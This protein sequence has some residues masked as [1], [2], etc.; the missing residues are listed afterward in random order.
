[1]VKIKLVLWL[2]SLNLTARAESGLNLV[3][4]LHQI[5]WMR[6]EGKSIGCDAVDQSV[7]VHHN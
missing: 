3:A 1:M 2:S 4:Q 7:P 5:L 6:I